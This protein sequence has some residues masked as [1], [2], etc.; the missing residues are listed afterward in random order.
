MQAITIKYL[1][2]TANRPSRFKAVCAR[3]SLTQSKDSLAYECGSSTQAA[4]FLAQ[5]L[6]LKFLREDLKR[7]EPIDKNNWNRKLTEAFDY[8]EQ[9][10]FFPSGER[11]SLFQA[12]PPEKN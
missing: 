10:V 4:E 11:G 6:I 2:C 3:G 1:G 12:L 7:G 5:K 8:K 9:P